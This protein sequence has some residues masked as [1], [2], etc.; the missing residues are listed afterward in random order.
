MCYVRLV[1]FSLRLGMFYLR[2]S[3]DDNEYNEKSNEPLTTDQAK[4]L[5]FAPQFALRWP[6]SCPYGRKSLRINHPSPTKVPSK[7]SKSSPAVNKADSSATH[8]RQR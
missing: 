1:V 5:R 7:R 6:T 3:N 2:H 4:P 8:W